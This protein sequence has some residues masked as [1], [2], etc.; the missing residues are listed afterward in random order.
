MT[1]LLIRGRELTNYL[2]AAIWL[3]T[4]LV[5]GPILLGRFDVFPTLAAVFALL[6]ASSARKFGSVLAIGALLKVW[7][8]LLL[9]AT[10]EKMLTRV[11]LWFALTFGLGSLLLGIWWDESFLLSADK[12]LAACRLN[13]SQRCHINSGMPVQ[14][15]WLQHFN[16][17][18][19]K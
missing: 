14:Q 4:P 10:P 9:L 5:M 16:L 7:P 13:P 8:I 12:V 19:L 1:L 17:A 6:Y 15:V 11:L 3:A 2:P 18:Q